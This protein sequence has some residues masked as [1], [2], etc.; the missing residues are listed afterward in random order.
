MEKAPRTT[1]TTTSSSTTSLD[2]PSAEP[3]AHGGLSH[4]CCSHYRNDWFYRFTSVTLS[5]SGFSST[6]KAA[7]LPLLHFLVRHQACSRHRQVLLRVHN[8]LQN[9]V[10]PKRVRECDPQHVSKVFLLTSSSTACPSGMQHLPRRQFQ[11]RWVP[12]RPALVQQRLLRL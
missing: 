7:L 4:G 12:N 3:R 1:A 2:L 10:Q 11:Q 9:R 5:C 8:L 6:A